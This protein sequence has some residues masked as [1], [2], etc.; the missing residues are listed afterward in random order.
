VLRRAV[1]ITPVDHPDLAAYLPNLG[2]Q[3]QRRFERT[4]RIKNLEEAIQ[5]SRRAVDTTPVDHPNLAVCLNNLGNQL[6]SQFERTRRI[7]DLEE[8]IQASRRAVDTTPVDHHNLAAYLNNLGNH[9]Q[10]QFERT[11][12]IEDL[13]EA[14]QVSRRAVDITPV[15][16]PSLAIYLP[17]LGARL[18]R[19]FERTGRIRDL[20]EA[21]QASRRAVDTTPVDHPGPSKRPKT[22]VL[23]TTTDIASL[24]SLEHIPKSSIQPAEVYKIFLDRSQ[25]T[26]LNRTWLLTR[27]FF[28]IASPDAFYQLR[29]ACTSIRENGVFTLLQ[30]TNSIAQ[31][32][33]ALDNLE[34]AALTN[35]ILRRYHLTRLVDHRNERKIYHRNKR[36]KRA[37]RVAK[38]SSE[39]HK[40][41]SSLALADLMAQA[42]PKLKSLP[43]DRGRSEK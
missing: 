1:D 36:P 14:I 40:R 26:D 25:S 8:A 41:A 7:E 11:G 19:Q 2:N 10:R 38:D 21:I 28:A 32:I 15:D 12:R 43:R 35:S 34:I 4:G 20:E 5:V 29:D 17:N 30:P 37:V 33:Q 39:S 3:L 42:Y 13:K 24:K 22:R 27:L 18:Q 6:Q 16:H 31:T 9:L 23:T